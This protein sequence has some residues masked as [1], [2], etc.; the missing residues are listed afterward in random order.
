M[1]TARV[2]LPRE[3]YPPRED[4]ELILPFARGN[5]GRWLLEIGC[6]SGV[7]AMEA[8]RGGARVIATDRNPFAVA[9]VAACA[10][11]AS[12]DLEVLR[13]DLASGV[14]PVDRILSNP[15]YLPTP[16][17]A[18]DPDPWHNLALDGGWDGCRV[19]ARI[20]AGLWEHLRSS[21][22]AFVV[23][24]SRQDPDRVRGILQEFT[25]RGGSVEIVARKA[26]PDE[27]L[28]VHRFRVGADR[29]SPA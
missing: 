8:A 7:I 28:V 12:L 18:R 11:R 15:P 3:V 6:G 10:A 29:A 26:L 14:R 24:S 4:T 17:S 5:A 19:L 25:E 16:A 1:E 13:T 21:G 27:V 20:V 23:G 2:P 9:F 22:E